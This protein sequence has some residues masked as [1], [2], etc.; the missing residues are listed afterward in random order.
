M[1][2]RTVNISHP[3]VTPTPPHSPCLTL[4]GLLEGEMLESR[5]KH[6]PS[7]GSEAGRCSWSLLLAAPPLP[8]LFLWPL[9]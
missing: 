2:S 8:Q 4:P 6:G 7:Q 5:V 9:P 1:V 3:D